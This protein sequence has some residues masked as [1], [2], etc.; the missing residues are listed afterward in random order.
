LSFQVQKYR[1]L[2]VLRC[3]ER[4]YEKKNTSRGITAAAPLPAPAWAYCDAARSPKGSSVA[5]GQLLEHKLFA[6]GASGD[7]T[8]NDPMGNGRF[9]CLYSSLYE[10]LKVRP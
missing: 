7:R 9:Q 2:F 1:S 6:S 5:L 3:Q 4:A 8:T 10:M